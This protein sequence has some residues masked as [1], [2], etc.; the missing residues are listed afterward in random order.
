MK[1]SLHTMIYSVVLG[2]VCAT[3]LTGV[4]RFTAD[5]RADNEQA[6]KNRNILEVLGVEFDRDASS[7]EL[8]KIFNENVRIEKRGDLETFVHPFDSDSPV[9]AVAVQ[10]AGSGLWGPIEGFLA[11]DAKMETIVG[12]TF[13]KQQETPGL[14]G[15][16]GGR[17]F[18]DK[19]KGKTIRDLTGKPGLRIVRGGA[20]G[21]NEVDAISGATMTCN[22]VEAM[23]NTVIVRIVEEQNKH[24]R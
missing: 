17:A 8:L 12:I 13:Y 3:A 11:L 18:R 9:Q 2:L 15:E 14:G 23:V 20:V 22:K 4:E 1:D 10:F 24:G 7:K 16:I 6:E 19:F 5:R 21:P